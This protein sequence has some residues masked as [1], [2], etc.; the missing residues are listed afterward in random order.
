MTEN[1]GDSV[2]EVRDVLKRYGATVALAG[3]SI[4][5]APGEVHALIGENGAGKSTLV[6]ILSGVVAADTGDV[7]LGGGVYRPQSIRDA[8]AAGV[9]TAFQELSLLPNLSVAANLLLP[10]LPKGALG[11][12]SGKAVIDA[13]RETL[14]R[15]GAAEIDPAA[16]VE[17]LSLAKKQ[18]VEI[19]RAISQHPRV[20]ILDEP[21]AALADPEWLFRLIEALRNEG[22]AVLYISHR[23]IEVRRL[24]Q[25]GTV[26]RN[27]HSVETVDLASTRDEEIFRMMVGVSPSAAV[28]EQPQH[29]PT[30]GREAL[31]ARHLHGRNVS[32]VS[33]DLHEGEVLGVAGLEGQGQ[34]ELFRM[35]GGVDAI[36]GGA[37]EVGGQQRRFRS[38]ANAIKTGAGIAFV[39]E[40]RKTEGAFLGMSTSANMSLSI[41]D[42]LR[43]CGLIDFRRE[44]DRVSAESQ[45]VDLNARYLGMKLSALSGG[46]QQKALLGRVLLSG[47]KVLV[48]FDPT[49]GVDVGT[50]Q[51]IYGV[52]RRFAAA[53]G[54]IL[55]YSTEIPELV[56][57]VDRCLVIYRSGII[58]ELAHSEMSEHTLVA[59]A[60]GHAV[61]EAVRSEVSR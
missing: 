51:V 33:F 6:K 26:L 50:K 20:L 61:R 59:M 24:C 25:R 23:L 46:N 43:R 5:V 28:I 60:T 57:L 36:E 48:M 16:L 19:V 9:S 10:R 49:R 21:T 40:E 15:Y 2:L 29:G 3:V 55:M 17:T 7:M 31:R 39:P 45:N 11:L 30:I 35:L 54:S 53:G 47:A 58:G 38:P 14:A 12:N 13:G 27:G 56:G 44:R 32:D 8:R 18:R 1:V 42:K 52:I 41:I 4:S 34:R 37:I 22:T